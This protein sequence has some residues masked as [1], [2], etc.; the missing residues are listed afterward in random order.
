MRDYHANLNPLTEILTNTGVIVALTSEG[1][2]ILTLPLDYGVWTQS[3]SYLIKANQ[4]L[5][6]IGDLDVW[7]TGKVSPKAKIKLKE[8]GIE[9]HENALAILKPESA[10]TN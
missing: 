8:G 3:A 1:S 7:V 9:I 2:V 5:S 6:P 10:N 4:E